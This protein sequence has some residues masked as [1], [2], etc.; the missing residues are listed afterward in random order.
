MDFGA[1]YSIGNGSWPFSI[2]F[3]IDLNGDVLSDSTRI[4]AVG[5]TITFSTLPVTI[6]PGEYTGSYGISGKLYTGVQEINLVPA[7]SGSMDRGGRYGI[8]AAGRAGFFDLDSPC[9]IIP[10]ENIV[11]GTG[12]TAL[13]FNIS[14]DG[15]IIDTDA[16]TVV[17]TS[18]NFPMSSNPDQLDQDDDG[19]GDVCDEDLDGDM[20][21]NSIDNCPDFSNSDQADLDDD[22]V[23][24]PCDDDLDGDSISGDLDNC[25][26]VN[27]TDQA[28]GDNDLLGDACDDDDDNDNIIDLLDNC[29]TISN[30]D[31]VDSDGDDEGD[32]CD[33]DV[34]GDG[35]GNDV[36]AC[37]A[38]SAGI[39]I[40]EDG[41]SAVQQIDLNCIATKFT[42]HG[43]YVSCVSHTAID[44]V[45]LGV[46]SKKE[47][48]LL[49]TNAARNK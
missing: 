17:D 14:C 38:T 46:I 22:G 30:T 36:D 27:N 21:L 24:N 41:C 48:S 45:D 10:S 40:T 49:V 2:D 26:F 33:G 7:G 43:R 18:D 6:D 28:N 15:I 29:P 13:T 20:V 42:N 3:D 4:S 25:P 9:A 44:L 39:T 11:I 5:N 47:K 16:D 34:D 37:P 32:V 8:T 19:Q 23:G 35:V 1:R 31:Q 12:E